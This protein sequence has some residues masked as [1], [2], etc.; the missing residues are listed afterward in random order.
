MGDRHV[1][2]RNSFIVFGLL[3]L[4]IAGGAYWRF[5]RGPLVTAVPATRGTAAEIAGFGARTFAV[6]ADDASLTAFGP[7]PLDPR[8]RIPSALAGR[9]QG[10]RVAAAVRE[11]LA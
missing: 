5:G 4:A 2:R 6:F 3:L 7:N 10:R 9:E 11:F 1:P 8:C